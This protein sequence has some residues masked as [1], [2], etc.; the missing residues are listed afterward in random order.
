VSSLIWV[1]PRLEAEVGELKVI[2]DEL[3]NKYG[4]EFAQMCRSNRAQKVNEKLMIKMSEQA[5]DALLVEKY[6]LEIAKSHNV[7]FKPDSDLAVRDPYYFY[8]SVN[9]K[10]KNDNNNNNNNNSGGNG[11]NTDI[12]VSCRK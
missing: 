6:L 8:D 12:V 5:P 3:S 10:P 1:A 11:G 7:P 4:K 2:A 9:E